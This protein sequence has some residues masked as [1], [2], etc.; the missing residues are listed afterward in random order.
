MWML[1]IS[2]LSPRVERQAQ[3]RRLIPR[4]P[5]SVLYLDHINGKGVELYEQ[6]CKLD[7]EGVVAKP[8]HSPYRRLDGEVG[9]GEG[10]EPGLLAGGGA[11]GVVQPAAVTLL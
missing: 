11:G 1:W 6:C 4:T 5:S 2:G 7:L 3:R 8:K 9:V 10:E